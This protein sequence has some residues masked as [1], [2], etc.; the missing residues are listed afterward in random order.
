MRCKSW[1]NG[2]TGGWNIGRADCSGLKVPNVTALVSTA[3]PNRS[4]PV[5][6]E[7]LTAGWRAATAAASP[8]ATRMTPSDQSSHPAFFVAAQPA[9]ALTGTIATRALDM[10]HVAME[11]SHPA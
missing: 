10:R 5:R 2:L 8:P 7:V 9:L 4:A 11:A 6:L 3:A 1:I